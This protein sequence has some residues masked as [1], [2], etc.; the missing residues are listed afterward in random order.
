MSLFAAGEDPAMERHAAR[1]GDTG[2][3]E[4]PGRGE[5]RGCP[6]DQ[7]TASH[8][9]SALDGPRVWLGATRRL[10]LPEGMGIGI[11]PLQILYVN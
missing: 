8:Q 11:H 1:Q 5:S 3:T 7:L 10:H 9:R 6:H 4:R 2:Y